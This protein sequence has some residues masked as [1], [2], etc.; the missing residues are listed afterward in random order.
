MKSSNYKQRTVG[1]RTLRPETLMMGFGYSPA[2]SEGALKPPVFLTS[3]FVFE[4]AQQG[5]DQFDL[6]SG[7]RQAR[8]GEQAGLVY[9]RFN[10]PNF[11][12]LEDRVAVWDDAERGA[13]FA[14][15]MAAIATTLLTFCKPGDVVLHSRPLY[16]GTETLIRNTLSAFGIGSAGFTDGTDPEH[17]EAA[18]HAAME[19]GTVSVLFAETPANPTGGLID[20]KVLSDVADLVGTRQGKRPLVIVDNTLLGP[21]FQQPL[22]HGADLAVYSL[23]KY[24]GGHS[25]LIAGGVTGS[26]EHVGRIV[27]TRSALGTQLDP[28][29]CWM[30]LRSLETLQI[31]AERAAANARRLA[32]FLRDHDKITQVD[33]LGFLTA[34]D[35]RKAVFD[36]QST[37]PGSTFSFYVK[38]GE[39][40]AFAF[41]DRLQLC[42]LAVSLGGTE[43]LICH[44][45][46]TTHSGVPAPLREEIG[47]TD[48]LVRISVGIENVDDLIADLTQALDF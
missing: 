8:D 41:L 15:G 17:V 24:A 12:I 46:S 18:A 33:Y 21:M 31:R 43:T 25:D 47:L 29:T 44:P 36:R 45:A 3:T 35:P 5:K 13:V 10:N 9:S 20:L 40:E 11:E 7:R 23:T 1:D 48:S 28:N 32:E 14:S 26:A 19:Q 2:L 16:G 37:S 38:G 34:D 6:T 39:P 22:R 27:Q 42:K 30:L 4:T